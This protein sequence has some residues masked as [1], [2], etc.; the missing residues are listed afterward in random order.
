M[1]STANST[2]YPSNG[3]VITLEN[4]NGGFVGG[5]RDKGSRLNI[6]EKAHDW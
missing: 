6:V 3:D 1:N 2:Y 5:F 4:G